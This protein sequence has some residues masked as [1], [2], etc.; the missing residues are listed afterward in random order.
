[1]VRSG[2][3]SVSEIAGDGSRS[4]ASRARFVVR[5]GRGSVVRISDD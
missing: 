1:M 3:S 2:C 4:E 5:D